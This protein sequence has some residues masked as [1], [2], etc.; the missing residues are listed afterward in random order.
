[1][2]SLLDRLASPAEASFDVSDRTPP[3]LVFGTTLLIF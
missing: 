3:F 2:E 1:M